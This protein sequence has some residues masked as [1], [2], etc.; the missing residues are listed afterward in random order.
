M[1]VTGEAEQTNLKN[2]LKTSLNIFYGWLKTFCSLKPT[3]SV[4][5]SKKHFIGHLHFAKEKLD[6]YKALENVEL[7]KERCF[8]SFFK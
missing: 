6:W 1:L 4:D 3:C 5:C 2:K 8:V 7:Q